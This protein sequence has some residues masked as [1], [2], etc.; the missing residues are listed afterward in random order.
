M[1]PATTSACH[2]GNQFAFLL[3]SSGKRARVGG[4]DR[5]RRHHHHHRRRLC[6]CRAKCIEPGLWLES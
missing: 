4:H 5:H 3:L 2:L 1:L 6:S